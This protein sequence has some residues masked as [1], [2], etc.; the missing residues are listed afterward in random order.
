M[1]VDWEKKAPKSEPIVIHYESP[2]IE[3]KKT[4]VRFV[5]DKDG[6]LIMTIFEEG[7]KNGIT[8]SDFYRAKESN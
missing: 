6:N 2:K 4:E 5:P 8:V 3:R 1:S 7:D